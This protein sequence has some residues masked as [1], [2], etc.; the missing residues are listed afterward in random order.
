M[1]DRLPNQSNRSKKKQQKTIGLVPAAGKAARLYPLPFSKELYPIG[2]Q[3]L[4][5]DRDL[6]PK[7]VC[8]YLLENMRRASISEAFIVLRKGKWDIPAYLG[9]GNM[10][11][12]HL[13]YLMMR[14]T[15]GVPYT[16]DQAYSFLKDSIVALG[17][18]DIIFRPQDAFESLINRQSESN[19]DAVLGLFPAHQSNK[20][21]MVDLDA[22]GRIRKI[23][24]RP[25]R[26]NLRYAWII[27]VWTPVFTQFMHD[28]LIGLQGRSSRPD[29]GSNPSGRGELVVGNVIRA[30]IHH[31][32]N[33]EGV[34]FENGF[35]LDIGTPDNLRKALRQSVLQERIEYE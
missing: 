12:M 15:S 23:Q 31:H 9:D 5:N 6:T 25:A 11:N 35:Y 20:T 22:N 16:L 27:A 3:R 13:A 30:A 8:V 34:T 32:L 24:I 17:Y 4:D 14:L 1:S 21:D 28:Y 2:L 29:V 10:L 33:V 18:P 7:P 19:A 26:T